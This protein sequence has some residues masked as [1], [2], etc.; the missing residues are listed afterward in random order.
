MARYREEGISKANSFLLQECGAIR[1][2]DSEAQSVEGRNLVA[3]GSWS[4]KRQP[5]CTGSMSAWIISF[6]FLSRTFFF[7]TD[8]RFYVASRRRG[9]L[10]VPSESQRRSEVSAAGRLIGEL[11]RDA[12]RLIATANPEPTRMILG[13]NSIPTGIAG[14]R[15][16][17]RN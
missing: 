16:K 11:L 15:R 12:F 2:P 13:P 7:S 10:V 17:R 1:L 6:R 9:R 14:F 4:C 8:P 3:V 5:P